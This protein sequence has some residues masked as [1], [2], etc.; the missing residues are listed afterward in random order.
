MSAPEQK[1]SPPS[2]GSPPIGFGIFLLI[3]GLALLAERMGWMP[4]DIEWG[5]PLVLITWGLSTL[6]EKLRK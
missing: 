2:S 4:N 3:A 6:I 1:S 5:L